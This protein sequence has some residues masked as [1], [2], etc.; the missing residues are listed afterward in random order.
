MARSLKDLPGVVHARVHL[1]LPD[2]RALV[3]DSQP[4]AARASVLLQTQAGAKVVTSDVQ[5][6]IAGG[7]QGLSPTEVTVVVTE[8]PRQ[9][10]ANAG[11]SHVGPVAVAP[12]SAALLRG[13]LVASA[14]LHA[15]LAAAVICLWTLRRRSG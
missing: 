12:G 8:Q 5:R 3:L 6:L 9:P 2:E 14:L 11:W 7:V 1:A 15:A 10:V 13:M 4:A